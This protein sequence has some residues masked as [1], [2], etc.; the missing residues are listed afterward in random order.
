M[1]EMARI[2]VFEY[3]YR[4]LQASVEVLVYAFH[5]QLRQPFVMDIAEHPFGGVREGT[6]TYIVQQYG[7]LH[8]Q[9]LFVTYLHPF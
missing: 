1:Q 4:R 2:A 7:Q 9:C 8:T 3:L 5:K 6:V